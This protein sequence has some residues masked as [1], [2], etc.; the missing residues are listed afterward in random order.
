ML[1]FKY[2]FDNRL[3]FD[4]R[5]NWWHLLSF[6]IHD[7]QAFGSSF[8]KSAFYLSTPISEWCTASDDDNEEKYSSIFFR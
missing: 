8:A 2:F 6:L 3:A 4:A 1:I 7:I 5:L